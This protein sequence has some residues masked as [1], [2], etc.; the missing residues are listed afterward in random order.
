MKQCIFCKEYKEDSEFN[1]EHI[2]LESLGGNGNEDICFNVCKTCNSSLGTRVDACL[3][4]HEITKVMRYY[5][6]IKG[7]NGVPN[8][9]K[10][11]KIKYADTPFEG[12]L[13]T[14]KEGN[15]IGFRADYK[16]YENDGNVIIAGPKKGFVE[17]V[18]S[19]L[20]NLG[21]PSM[22]KEEILGNVLDLG[23]L[24]IPHINKIEFSE[25]LKTEYLNYAFP[26]MLKM[27]YEFCF[28]K[29]G[30]KYLDDPIA[31]DIRNFLMKF[32]YKKFEYYEC[33]TS[34][35]ISW[36]EE[37]RRFISLFLLKEENK[38]FVE[39][40]LYGCVLCTICMSKSIKNYSEFETAVLK[41]D[42]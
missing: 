7:K 31:I 8:P 38:I 3:V 33:P 37:S 12:K 21:K 11:Q 23:E 35:R 29:L 9:F 19:Q 1:R 14:D 6:K 28:V 30:K 20:E 41:I 26:T 40:N 22:T 25:E 36:L 13:K 5:F 39:I 2:I 15:I 34:A 4:N 24:K 27:A 32:D 16:I 10:K 18:N 42:I 17:Y